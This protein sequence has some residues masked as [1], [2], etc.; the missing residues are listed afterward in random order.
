MN[1]IAMLLCGLLALSVPTI[2]ASD[3]AGEF[4]YYVVALSWSPNWCAREGDAR[5][6]DQC[7]AGTGYGWTLHGL[8]PQ[9]EDGYPEY[10]RTSKRDPS[11]NQSDTM[12]DI[13]GSGGLAWHQWKKHGRCTGL[14]GKD[15]YAVS[16]LA[17]ERIVRP[18]LLRQLDEPVR[19]PASVIE[20][21][22]LEANPDLA[23]DMLTITCRDG[24]IAE[25]RI[26]MTRDL[27]PRI[28]GADVR[29]DCNN[30]NA[31]FNPLR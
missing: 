5:D 15:Y 19:L 30:S 12:E 18:A 27:K 29:R 21:A 2:S 9:Y 24:G 14:S 7:D 31:V 10:C 6:S 4:D 3:T 8:W 13:M 17:Y 28:C 16:R 1:R 25:A 23:P 22:F 20:A 11:R 26:C